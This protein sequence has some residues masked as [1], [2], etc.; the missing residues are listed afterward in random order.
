ME[1]HLGK[2]EGQ[3]QEQVS[4]VVFLECGFFPVLDVLHHQTYELG[5]VSPVFLFTS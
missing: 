1:F 4:L 2:E 3:S 5:M